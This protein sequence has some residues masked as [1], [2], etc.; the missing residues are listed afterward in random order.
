MSSH[1]DI[2]FI[3][4]KKRFLKIDF[5]WTNNS[6]ITYIY[7]LKDLNFLILVFN[8]QRM[9]FNIINNRIHMRINANFQIIYTFI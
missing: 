6:N 8:D 2:L 7:D 9:N 4:F 3:L 1:S 5:W